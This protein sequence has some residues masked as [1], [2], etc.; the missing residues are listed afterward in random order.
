MMM[1]GVSRP[2]CSAIS[3][4]RMWRLRWRPFL[5]IQTRNCAW[6]AA[7]SA[8]PA[9]KL[10]L[11]RAL[12][13]CDIAAVGDALKTY[14]NDD[15]SFIRAE[16]IHALCKLGQFGAEIEALLGDP[17]SSVRLSAA[18]AIAGA[19]APDAV[20]KIVDFAFSFEGYHGVQ[21][22]RLL[23]RLDVVEASGRFM[24]TLRDP[25]QNRTWSVAIN[26]LAELNASQPRPAGLVDVNTSQL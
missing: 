11:I 12:A 25:E 15:D 17:D 7:A 8:E 5:T 13:A 1:Y 20:G 4:V 26:A 23:R 22:A 10:L 14:L 16:A 24:E 3:V 21:A 6:P 18:K 2:V 19:G 9:L